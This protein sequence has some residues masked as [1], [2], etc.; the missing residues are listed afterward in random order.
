MNISTKKWTHSYKQTKIPFF[1]FKNERVDT[2][3]GVFAVTGH[4][5][6]W[7]ALLTESQILK[8]ILMNKVTITFA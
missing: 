7:E 3:N 5:F 2:D 6:V 1:S 4:G 8:A